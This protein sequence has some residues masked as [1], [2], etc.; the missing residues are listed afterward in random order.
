MKNKIPKSELEKLFKKELSNPQISFD[1]TSWNQMEQLLNQNEKK[2]RP[3]FWFWILGGIIFIYALLYLQFNTN[4]IPAT[5]SKSSQNISTSPKDIDSFA[6]DEKV[7]V[8][9]Q[10]DP[11]DI[12]LKNNDKGI[13][14]QQTNNRSITKNVKK[15]TSIKIIKNPKK[16]LDEK[17]IKG[18][19]ASELKNFGTSLEKGHQPIINI[20]QLSYQAIKLLITPNLFIESPESNFEFQLNEDKRK[21][22][23]V[24]IGIG[25]EWS[26][27]PTNT[28]S[29]VDIRIDFRLEYVLSSRFSVFSG[30][31]YT[32]DSYLANK[33]DYTPERG[34]WTRSI[35]PETTSATCKILD[36]SMGLKYY[37]SGVDKSGV[38]ISLGVLS[39]LMINEKYYYKY[40]DPSADLVKNWM[41]GWENIHPFNTLNITAGYRL[42]IRDWASMQISP[43]INI[44]MSGI[45][46]GKVKL[47]SSGINIGFHF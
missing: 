15:N 20:E 9:A 23:L 40:A 44:P 17:N 1:E 33:E 19:I 6:N 36:I 12:I 11:G 24:G 46:H 32:S 2:R 16:I 5:L 8:S 35:A 26:S 21:K 25:A 41:G 3:V 30:L 13:K 14:V 43:F 29:D 7:I 39:R 4:S 22:V 42:Q 10:N 45:G 31:G 47:L 27:T 34:F 38:N 28:L 18:S 37:L